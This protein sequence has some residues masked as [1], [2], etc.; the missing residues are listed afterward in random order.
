MV[1]A[2][3]VDPLCGFLAETV[4]FLKSLGHDVVRINEILPANS[5]DEVIIEEAR[6]DSRIIPTRISTFPG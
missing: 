1:T 5:S 2:R 6:R 3:D 4:A